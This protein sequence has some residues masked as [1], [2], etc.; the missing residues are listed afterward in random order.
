MAQHSGYGIAAEIIEAHLID[1]SDNQVMVTDPVL[2]IAAAKNEDIISNTADDD[3]ITP[4]A[5]MQIRTSSTDEKIRTI[6][7]N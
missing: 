4:A 1:M 6:P 7:S 5:D 2:A 3:I